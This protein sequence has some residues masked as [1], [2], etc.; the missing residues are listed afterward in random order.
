MGP[1]SGIAGAN[2][3]TLAL[4]LP[5]AQSRGNGV[6]YAMH[7]VAR[8]GIRMIAPAD[9]PALNERG[10]GIFF[11]PSAFRGG[12][13]RKTHLERLRYFFIDTDHGS[14]PEQLARLLASPLV[15]TAIVETRR[16]YHSYFAITGAPTLAEWEGTQRQ[17]VEH[18]CADPNARDCCRLLRVPGYLIWKD[19][20][21]PVA[22]LT[23]HKTDARYTLADMQQAFGVPVAAVAPEIA[24]PY[25]ARS[26][27]GLT[28]GRG[29]IDLSALHATDQRVVLERVSGKAIVYGEVYSFRR[30]ATGNSNIVVNGKLSSCFVDRA[31]RIGSTS[32]GGPGI[33]QW[34]RWFGHSPPTVV[35]FLKSEFPE[36]ARAV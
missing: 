13:R 18:F 6:F 26:D 36:F 4:K 16:G 7:D 17:L 31:G 10:Y 22:A 20:S 23:V 3:Q 1:A 21:N 8:Q 34:L 24:A 2:N 11:T 19:P 28:V 29:D 25:V 12:L 15:W 14:K 35:A 5:H 30:T 33:F 32:N 9:A 27:V